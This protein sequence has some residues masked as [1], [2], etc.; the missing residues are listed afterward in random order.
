MHDALGD[1]SG[2][3]R[4]VGFRD[5]TKQLSVVTSIG[6]DA[7][8]R[9]FSGPRPAELHPFV[10]L[11]GRGTAPRRHRATCCSTSAPSRWTSASSWPPRSSRRWAGAITVVD[12]V[13]GF[14]FFDN[15]DL[16]GFV[17]GTENPDGPLAVQRHPDRRR[18]PRFR[19][20][21]LRARAEVP[22]RHGVLE[23]AVDR[24]AGAG[25]RPHQ[26][27]RHR[28]GRRRSSRRTR[29]SRSTSSRTTTATS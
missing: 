28:D 16:L 11:D 8:D 22:A 29:T 21:L 17:D 6:S 19:G 7:W 23:R 25:H 2:L 3:V 26:A 13:H 4:A 14:K 18:G 1:I 24:G 27:R 9:L 10:A 12:E 20:R 5:P 15:R